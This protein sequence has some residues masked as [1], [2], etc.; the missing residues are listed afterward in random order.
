MAK[1]YRSR[2]KNG[3]TYRY[4]ISP[5]MSKKAAYMIGDQLRREYP[6]EFVRVLRVNKQT[7]ASAKYAPFISYLFDNVRSWLPVEQDYG[8]GSII[9]QVT[10]KVLSNISGQNPYYV[11]MDPSSESILVFGRTASNEMSY[12]IDWPR[13]YPPDGKEGIVMVT[14]SGSKE[15]KKEFQ[16]NAMK[17]RIKDEIADIRTRQETSTIITDFQASQVHDLVSR[18]PGNTTFEIQRTE[19]SLT[20]FPMAG[21]GDILSFNVGDA[22]QPGKAT[23][24]F[25]GSALLE[26]LQAF[27]SSGSPNMLMELNSRNEPLYA[28]F[29][30]YDRKGYFYANDANAVKKTGTFNAIITPADSEPGSVPG[31]NI[32]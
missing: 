15:L 2:K 8:I 22:D 29:F 28:Q 25:S 18:F 11:H 19:D 5:G 1:Q 13:S 4:P 31:A 3:K 9:P 6:D 20:V 24:F 21:S 14:G 23:S 17:T 12:F 26:L 30:L 10:G 27:Q 7:G 16:L 32:Y